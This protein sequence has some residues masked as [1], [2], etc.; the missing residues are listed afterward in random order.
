MEIYQKKIN[1][2]WTNVVEINSIFSEN[3]TKRFITLVSLKIRL[4]L[5]FT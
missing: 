5:W 2:T 3:Q 4:A 1:K